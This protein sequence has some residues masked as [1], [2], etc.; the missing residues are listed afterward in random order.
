MVDDVQVK[1]IICKRLAKLLCFSYNPSLPYSK[2]EMRVND[3]QDDAEKGF[4]NHNPTLA[5]VE[6][7]STV[8]D[9]VLINIQALLERKARSK[10]AERDRA[11]KEAKIR[12][13]WMLAAVVIN[14][15]C[16]VFFT[17]VLIGV[18][19]AFFVM[20]HLHH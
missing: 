7:M 1:R 8:S 4:L 16:F 12:Q 15:L 10:E 11:S 19:L 18:T 14:R 3:A 9:P 6:A 20:F 5:P 2:I 17:V 13:E